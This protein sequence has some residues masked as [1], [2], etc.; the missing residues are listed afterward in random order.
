MLSVGLPY[1]SNAAPP[2]Y[3]SQNIP[4]SVRFPFFPTLSH[5]TKQPTPRNRVLANLRGSPV[6]KS[7]AI[8][9][10]RRF[11]AV[12]TTPA[13]CPSAVHSL[14]SRSFKIYFIIILATTSRAFEG[15]PS[16]P[17]PCT[18]FPLSMRA[19]CPAHLLLLQLTQITSTYGKN[20][21]SVT[22]HR[23]SYFYIYPLCF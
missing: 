19:I 2:P 4:V 7:R 8:H 14:Q 11:L 5:D 15:Y 20:Y 3:P 9:E 23:S 18:C 1:S 6:K 16:R 10:T 13:T 21:K 17:E 22:I 12:L